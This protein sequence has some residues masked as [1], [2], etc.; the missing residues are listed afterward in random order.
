MEFGLMKELYWEDHKLSI[1]RLKL[2]AQT[3]K[4]QLKKRLTRSA[5]KWPKVGNSKAELLPSHT[6]IRSQLRQN[7]LYLSLSLKHSTLIVQIQTSQ[8]HT[9]LH[10]MCGLLYRMMVK[11]QPQQS[12]KCVD[13]TSLQALNLCAHLLPALSPLNTSNVKFAIP[14]GRMI[15]LLWSEHFRLR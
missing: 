7:K 14:T 6:Q 11:L 3:L 9:P 10:F 8:I 1:L 4:Q 13:T 15:T 2:Q 5:K 12:S